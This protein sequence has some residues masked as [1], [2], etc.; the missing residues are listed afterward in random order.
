L[1]EIEQ[2]VS[3]MDIAMKNSKDG[4]ILGQ[5]SQEVINLSRKFP[6]YKE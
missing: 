4:D 6:V 2:I 1:D 5:I 3:W